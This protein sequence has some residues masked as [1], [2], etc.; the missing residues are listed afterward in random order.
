[1]YFK[2]LGAL[3]LIDSGES[4]SKIIV[5]RQEEAGSIQDISSLE[6]MKPGKRKA[7][8]RCFFAGWSVVLIP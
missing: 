6:N 1:M 2:V 3:R 8:R 5:I 4:D 7:H